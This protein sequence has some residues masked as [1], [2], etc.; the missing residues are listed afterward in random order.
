MRKTLEKNK[1]L[2]Q[3]KE[4]INKKTAIKIEDI[5]KYPFIANKDK[6]MNLKSI[7]VKVQRKLIDLFEFSLDADL[8]I[9]YNKLF[10]TDSGFSLKW[11]NFCFS[12]ATYYRKLKQLFLAIFWL[13]A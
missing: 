11:N 10:K 8:R 1:E 3:Y 12:K 13:I 9:I 5:K 4:L 6:L 7:F 2:A